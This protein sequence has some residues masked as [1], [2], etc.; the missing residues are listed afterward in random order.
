ME[1]G[2]IGVC[3][4]MG[5]ECVSGIIVQMI[6]RKISKPRKLKLQRKFK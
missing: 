5:A 4:E 2:V 6:G 1:G 3:V